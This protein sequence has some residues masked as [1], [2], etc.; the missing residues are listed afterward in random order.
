MKPKCKKGD[1]ECMMMGGKDIMEE[2]GPDGIMGMK[3]MDPEEMFKKM[4]GKEG[5]NKMRT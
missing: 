1:E 3:E 5:M 2:M 4:G